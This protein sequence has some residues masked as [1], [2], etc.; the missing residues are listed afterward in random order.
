MNTLTITRHLQ[1]ADPQLVAPL[2]YSAL[3]GLI[4]PQV[5]QYILTLDMVFT[6][7]LHLGLSLEPALPFNCLLNAFNLILSGEVIEKLILLA[8]FSLAGIGMHRLV[9]GASKSAQPRRS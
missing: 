2:A 6:P 5:G 4:V 3:S 7:K 9:V 8:V 1:R